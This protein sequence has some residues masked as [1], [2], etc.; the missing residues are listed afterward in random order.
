MLEKDVELHREI[1]VRVVGWALRLQ[2]QAIRLAG[3]KVLLVIVHDSHG[4]QARVRGQTLSLHVEFVGR[5]VHRGLCF[6]HHADCVLIIVES[7]FRRRLR[8][9]SLQTVPINQ[10]V[11]HV[12]STLGGHPVVLSNVLGI[13][14]PPQ[15]F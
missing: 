4:A 2:T 14:Q 13:G 3:R 5:R 11:S 8:R 10:R 7:L 1:V 12:G 9:S 6:A 15:Q